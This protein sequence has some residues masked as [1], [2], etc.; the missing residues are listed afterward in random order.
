MQKV[1]FTHMFV[2]LVNKNKEE[3][4]AEY[5]TSFERYTPM[6]DQYFGQGNSFLMNVGRSR[7]VMTDTKVEDSHLR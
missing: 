7:V 2:V 4:V 3:N 1:Q 5:F 6:K